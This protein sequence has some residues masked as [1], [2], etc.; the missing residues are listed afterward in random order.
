M[1]R[2]NVCSG[3]RKSRGVGSG[4]PRGP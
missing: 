2:R 3:R 4:H 1:A